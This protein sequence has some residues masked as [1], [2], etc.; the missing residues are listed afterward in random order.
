MMRLLT[1]A[2]LLLAI[3]APAARGASSPREVLAS[4][5]PSVEL[6]TFLDGTV[7]SLGTRDPNFGKAKFRVASQPRG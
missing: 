2:T 1:L 7:A 4:M 5:R 6:Q 3:P